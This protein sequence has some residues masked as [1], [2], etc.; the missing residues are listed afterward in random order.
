M[1][2]CRAFDCAL[3]HPDG[4]HAIVVEPVA[5]LPLV[6]EQLHA[7]ILALVLQHHPRNAKPR[8]S[9]AEPLSKQS[10]SN[11]TAS[12]HPRQKRNRIPA[13]NSAPSSQI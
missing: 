11:S 2:L 12:N 4:E 10:L 7:Q 8:L 6:P 3:E 9:A 13:E 1:R 5:T